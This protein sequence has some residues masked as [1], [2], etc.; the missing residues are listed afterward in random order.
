MQ[1]KNA[2]WIVLALIIGVGIGY[3]LKSAPVNPEDQGARAGSANL[4]FSQN[5]V[6]FNSDGSCTVAASNGTLI[7]GRTVGVAPRLICVN[8]DYYGQD[9][10]RGV[11]NFQTN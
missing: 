4:P 7:T 8:G 10:S 2:L 5:G 9:G 11:V 3:M 6:T 1:S